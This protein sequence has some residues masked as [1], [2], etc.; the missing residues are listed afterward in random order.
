MTKLDIKAQTIAYYDNN[1]QA[2]TSSHGGYEKEYWWKDQI[3]IFHNYLPKGRVLEI[4]AG[5]GK[6]AE[7]L[8]NLGYDYVGTDASKELLK[9]AKERNP[10][11]VFLNK[12]VQELDLTLGEFDGF[13]ASAVLLH[14]PK[15]EMVDILKCISIVLKDN[16]IGFITMKKGRGEEVDEKTG[17]HYSYF[18]KE[19][20]EDLLNLANF[21]VLEGGIIDREGEKWLIFHVTKISK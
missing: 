5:A 1:A 8:I 13:W 19:E 11:A 10:N 15:D 21:E 6:D 3:K 12:L 9:I 16:G 2:W 18:Q 4:G 17:R 7:S 14:I 20:F